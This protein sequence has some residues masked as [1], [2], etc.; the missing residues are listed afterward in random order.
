MMTDL[1]DRK[2]IRFPSV[3]MLVLGLVLLCGQTSADQI[4]NEAIEL[5]P[6]SAHP[7]TTGEVR[8]ELEDFLMEGDP[9]AC[10]II[11]DLT[12]D[13]K[14][15]ELFV[16]CE[17]KRV[18]GVGEVRVFD[19]SGAYKRTIMPLNPTL[20]Y[21]SVRDICQQVVRED[22][23]ELIVPK[24]D[25]SWGEPSFYGSFWDSH[26]KI[27]LAPD[28]DLVI[29]D[30]YRGKLMRIGTD[31]SLPE[32]GWNTGYAVHVTGNRGSAIVNYLPFD[33]LRYPYFHFGPDGSMYVS[34]GQSSF[35]SRYHHYN[36]EGGANNPKYHFPIQGDRSGYVWK[37]GLKPGPEAEKQGITEAY[38]DVART[39]IVYETE[40]LS[41]TDKRVQAAF[42]IRVFRL[43]SDRIAV[44]FEDVTEQ[45]IAEQELEQRERQFRQL[46]DNINEVFWLYDLKKGHFVYISPA[47]KNIWGTAPEKLPV[48]EWYVLK[49]IHPEDRT[50]TPSYSDLSGDQLERNLEY[51]IIRDDKSIRWIR[52][53]RFPVFGEKDT[54]T[55]IAGLWT[56]ITGFKEAAEREKIHRQQLQQ[57]DKMASLGI[58]VSGV[59]HEVNNPNNFIMLNAP[60]LRE[61][62]EDA[63]PVLAAYYKKH[64]EFELGGLPYPEMSETIPKLF[65]GIEHGANRIKLIV[66]DLKNYARKDTSH[67]DSTVDLNRVVQEASS[68]MKNLIGKCTESY[69]VSP[70]TERVLVRGNRQKLEQV[71][72]NL[73]QNSCYALQSKSASITVKV[74]S[75]KMEHRIIVEDEGAGIPENDIPQ[76]TDPF[77]TTRRTEGGT[78]LGLSVSAGIIQE[79]NGRL[80]FESTVGK[81]T[82]ASIILPRLQ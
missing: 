18:G 22:G 39:G 47:F 63:K 74:V 41:Y 20:P 38:L 48:K 62:W 13:A 8:L 72:I 40:N 3:A 82:T 43:P 67:Y 42:R 33:S 49:S 60:L 31:G 54:I 68:L 61:T 6:G 17:P 12:A 77:F 51:R 2:A 14:K 58:L 55:R 10:G 7:G 52:E 35:E 44:A 4:R 50:H 81:G 70:E 79:H 32:E 34:G 37:L 11:W 45:V 73:I 36:L 59:A 21:S 5:G 53:R 25:L 71:V 24:F 78:G 64:P 9:H 56:D 29:S 57:A 27:A 46:V 19:R 15:G 30:L 76:I 75:G 28:G 65:D 23:T 1:R 16:L 66:E 69:T 26:K 80:L